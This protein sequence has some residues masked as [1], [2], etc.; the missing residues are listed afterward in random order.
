[1]IEDVRS[2]VAACSISA[3]SKS[4]RQRLAGLS[5]PLPIPSRPWSYLSVD[6]ITGLPTSQRSACYG[7]VLKSMHFV[8][9]A[10]KSSWRTLKEC[11]MALKLIWRLVNTVSKEGPDIQNGVVCVEVDQGI[12]RSKSD[13]IDIYREKSWPVW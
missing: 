2:F 3:Q 13:I 6:F 1:M 4:S 12:T 8:L 7:W 10:F 11:C 5:Q 9:L